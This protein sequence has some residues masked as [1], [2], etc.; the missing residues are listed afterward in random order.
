MDQ[1]W[2]EGHAHE[3]Y[4]RGTCARDRYAR[5]DISVVLMLAIY[6]QRRHILVRHIPIRT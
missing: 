6:M 2:F 1:L 4:A 5:G 3:A